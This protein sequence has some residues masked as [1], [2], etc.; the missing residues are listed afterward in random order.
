MWRARK[1]RSWQML[2]PHI[3]DEFGSTSTLSNSIVRF[4]ALAIVYLLSR[5]RSMRP[6]APCVRLFQSSMASSTSVRLV[7]RDDRPF[8]DEI[9]VRVG[10]DGGHLDDHVRCRA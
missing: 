8:A 2:L 10:D 3:G 7:D 4:S 1:R 5:T 9:E 6:E